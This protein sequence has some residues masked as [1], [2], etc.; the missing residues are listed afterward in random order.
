[1]IRYVCKVL[2]RIGRKP[3]DYFPL[4]EI[5]DAELLQI[6]ESSPFYTIQEC[7]FPTKLES[8]IKYSRRIRDRYQVSGHLFIIELNEHI[9]KLKMRKQ[10]LLVIKKKLDGRG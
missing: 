7:E 9:N 4:K 10:Q 6:L 1:M 8:V 5:S 3:E 2:E